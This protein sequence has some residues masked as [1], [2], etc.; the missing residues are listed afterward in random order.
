MHLGPRDF[1]HWIGHDQGWFES[2][3]AVN[4]C[5]WVFDADLA[6]KSF[7]YVAEQAPDADVIL[8]NGMCNFRS[9]ENGLPQRPLHLTPMLEGRLD[10]CIVG[11]DTALYWRIFRSLGIAPEGDHG[12]LLGSL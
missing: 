9:G 1:R 7:E 6:L 3:E 12:R 10:K 5:R 8:I 2:Q 4:D 11:H